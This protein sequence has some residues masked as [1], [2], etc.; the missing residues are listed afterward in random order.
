MVTKVLKE[1]QSPIRK[2][3]THRPAQY[4]L[5]AINDEIEEL[6]N[7]VLNFDGEVREVGVTEKDFLIENQSDG[8]GR[9]AEE[10]HENGGNFEEGVG[11]QDDGRQERDTWDGG[12][13][14]NYTPKSCNAQEEGSRDEDNGPEE[15]LVLKMDSNG[16]S[17]DGVL[18]LEEYEL[19][20]LRNQQRKGG[21]L[22]Q[23]LP[24]APSK[25]A[26][27]V[28]E[29]DAM[30]IDEVSLDHAKTDMNVVLTIVNRITEE[31]SAPHC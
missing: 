14:N 23:R 1:M 21:Q 11:E 20:V 5:A 27:Q 30:D 29:S 7:R 31:L 28:Q 2:C 4:Q 13:T 25:V 17:L 16:D 18:E 26:I 12:I 10:D 22:K 8:L 6:P 19:I 24:T 9:G 3:V 15:R